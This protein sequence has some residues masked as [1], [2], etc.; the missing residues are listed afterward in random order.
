MPPQYV[1]EHAR[2]RPTLVFTALVRGLQIIAGLV[3]MRDG[4]KLTTYSRGPRRGSPG[5]GHRH[6][7]LGECR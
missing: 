7:G 1:N 2:R 5:R 3:T 6:R 4:G